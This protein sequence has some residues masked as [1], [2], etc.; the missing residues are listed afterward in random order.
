MA[1][2]KDDINS[3]KLIIYK[4]SS[5]NFNKKVIMFDKKM[6]EIIKNL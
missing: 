3:I 2:E 6:T 4:Y 1:K 5:K